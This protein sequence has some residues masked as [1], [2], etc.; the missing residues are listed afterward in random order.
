LGAF[1]TFRR[2]EMQPL[3]FDSGCSR[4]CRRAG[5][6]TIFA[7]SQTSMCKWETSALWTIPDLQTG[8]SVLLGKHRRLI[9]LELDRESFQ[10]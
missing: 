9:Q 6:M 1:D 3:R 7:A 10:G 2:L 4:V 5:V 8:M